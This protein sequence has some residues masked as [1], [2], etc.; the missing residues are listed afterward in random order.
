VQRFSH[1]KSDKPGQE[2][3][4]RVCVSFWA[5]TQQSQAMTLDPIEALRYE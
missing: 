3:L 5:G 1:H 4:L 2:F